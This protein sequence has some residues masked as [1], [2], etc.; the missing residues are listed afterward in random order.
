ME[1]SAL[2]L[3]LF[4]A[5]E[6]LRP[7]FDCFEGL[8]TVRDYLSSFTVEA[9][10]NVIS[11]KDKWQR[12]VNPNDRR[13]KGMFNYL[14]EEETGF[15][16][17][18]IFVNRLKIEQQINV[19]HQ[20]AVVGC[21]EPD[22]ERFINDGQGRHTAF[23]K[24]LEHLRSAEVVDEAAIEKLLDRTL[25]LK[26]IVTNTDSLDEVKEAIRKLFS[27]IHLN[28]V[29]PNTSL[30][31]YFS[32]EP[33]SRLMRAL[34]ETVSVED[35]P[36]YDRIALNG[37]IKQ[38]QIWNLQQ[39]RTLVLRVMGAATAKANKLLKDPIAFEEWKLTLTKVL[40]ELLAQLPVSQLDSDE[41]SKV[42]QTSLY[43]KALAA[44]GLGYLARSMLEFALRQQEKVDFTVLR[45]LQELEL[46]NMA[47]K[48]WVSDKVCF[49]D[50]ATVKITPKS[51]KLIGNLLC[52][53]LSVFP[54]KSLI[55]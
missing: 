19:G 34:C 55:T 44:E 53:H 32:D 43:T 16:G 41:W 40:T 3:S 50:G 35:K 7:T 29:K 20:V 21:L 2:H 14:D 23:S 8:I 48:L 37:E 5:N 54:A 22:A 52:N 45:G 24:K 33:V 51:G 25:G 30:S 11:E 12:D 9:N 13:V 47:S 4:K 28:L 18:I 27:D 31:L 42:H 15:T 1:F 46:D 26:L 49:K 39:F 36:L 38:G 17:I 6:Y 10:S